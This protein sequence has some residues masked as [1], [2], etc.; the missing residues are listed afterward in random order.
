MKIAPQTGEVTL[1]NGFIFDA[2]LTQ[3]AFEAQ[4]FHDPA[5]VYNH[6]TPWFY[7]PFVA[8]KP[9]GHPL[10]LNLCFYQ[11]VLVSFEL[12]LNLYPEGAKW[13]NFS[14]AREERTQELHIRLVKDWFGAPHKTKRV[15]SVPQECSAL[16][17]ALLY[18]F[19]WGV[20]WCGYDERSGGTRVV[21]RYTKNDEWA[22]QDY[23]S[24]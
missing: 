20:A 5:R 9:E 10:I 22:R 2:S 6:R 12:T 17:E 24:R 18:D 8:E 7:H 4:K 11:N 19:E 21:V 15:N 14:Y 1:Q 3:T 16:A 13:S 23:Q